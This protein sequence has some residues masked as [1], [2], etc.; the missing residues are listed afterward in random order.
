MASVGP[1][2]A[3]LADTAD[4]AMILKIAT[5]SI[6]IAGIVGFS[7]PVPNAPAPAPVVGPVIAAPVAETATTTPKPSQKPK[8]PKK[9]DAFRS[10][11]TCVE[12]D[13]GTVG[14]ELTQKGFYQVRGLG[15]GLIDYYFLKKR[16]NE[17]PL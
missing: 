16:E 14:H 10:L 5:V 4:R 7:P 2:H 15:R 1:E 8:C 6:L 13:E 12:G 17:K 3:F 9:S 11:I